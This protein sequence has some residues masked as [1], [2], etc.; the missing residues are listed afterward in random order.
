MTRVE[1]Y[2]R[3]WGERD[4]LSRGAGLPIPGCPWTKAHLETVA[5]AAQGKTYK[6][7]AAVRCCAKSTV[8]A[9]LNNARL[10]AFTDTEDPLLLRELIKSPRVQGWLKKHAEIRNGQGV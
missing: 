1:G 4:P 2:H 3:N 7:I 8:K 6:E 9:T 5:L 10:V